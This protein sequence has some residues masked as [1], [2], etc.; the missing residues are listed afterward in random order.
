MHDAPT[1]PPTDPPLGS[2]AS[3]PPADLPA[4]P[5]APLT[6]DALLAHLDACGFR[7]RTLDHPAVFTVAESSALHREMDRQVEGAH[8]KN[9]FLRDR[10]NNH[11]LVTAEQ[12][13]QVDLKRL[14]K[15]IGGRSRFSFGRAEEMM[16][17]LGVSPGS[18]TAFGILN[19]RENRVRFVLDERLTRHER[20]NCH[21]LTNEATTSIRR[22]DLLAL[23]RAC[24]HAPLVADLTGASLPAED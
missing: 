2:Q 10:K 23:A 7:T 20:I 5:P 19:D 6:R 9:L 13:T 4:P 11:F 16:A 12:T 8:T 18:V 3:D 15:V 1:D 24:D 22:D 14:H 17:W 21:P